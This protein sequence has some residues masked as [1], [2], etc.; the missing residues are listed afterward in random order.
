MF[1]HATHLESLVFTSFVEKVLEISSHDPDLENK[2]TQPDD[3]NT[4]QVFFRHGTRGRNH[5]I[6][7]F[8]FSAIRKDKISLHT[9]ESFSLKNT[10]CN[11]NKSSWRKIDIML[12]RDFFGTSTKERRRRIPR[13]ILLLINIFI[14]IRL[15]YNFTKLENCFE[16][17]LVEFLILVYIL[18]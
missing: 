12:K 8:S 14:R 1:Y 10:E 15:E 5:H 9:C 7:P 6:L 13:L 11:I 3:K 16:S 4:F 2:L 18:R 17:G